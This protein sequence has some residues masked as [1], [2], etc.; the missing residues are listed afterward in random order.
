MNLSTVR[1][2]PFCNAA[3]PAAAKFCPGCGRGVPLAGDQTSG[4][5]NLGTVE[6]GSSLLTV[7]DDGPAPP[8]PID[9]GQFV[10]GRV[11][12]DRYRIVGL[13]GKGGMGEVYRADDLKLHQVVALKFLPA[14][15]ADDSLR[16]DRL[17]N[18]A[19]TARQNTHPH[20][21]RSYDLGEN[22]YDA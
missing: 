7:S 6:A 3:L 14:A 4:V 15:L 21:F 11:L 5:T 1:L 19:R 12:A 16:L 17:R 8:R 13:L 9:N 10:P 18:E 2:C 22:Y 20:I